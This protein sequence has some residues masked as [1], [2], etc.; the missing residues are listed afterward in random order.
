MADASLPALFSKRFGDTP[1]VPAELADNAALKRLAGRA[2]CRHFNDRTVDLD[3]LE[4]LCAAALSA[5]SKSDLQQRDILIVTDADLRA[6]L[7]SLLAAQQWIAEAPSM[8]VFL[9]NNRRQRQIQ[10]WHG[11]PFPNDHLDAF[12]NASLDAGIALATFLAAAEAAGLGCCPISTI[13]NHLPEV[14][15]LLRLPDH[16]FPVAAMAVGHPAGPQRVSA[17]L[18]L[19]ATVHHNHFDDCTQAHVTAYDTRRLDR[20]EGPGWS[21]AKAR[22]YAAPQRTDFGAFI[23]AIGFKLE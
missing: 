21:E 18:P 10:A 19:A 20:A 2:S 9:A 8:V 13:R 23:R 7:K 3:L 4:T 12:F 14:R 11:Q 22:M 1:R 17:R 15:D 5:P 16:V 6:A